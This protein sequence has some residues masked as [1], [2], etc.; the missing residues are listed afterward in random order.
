MS[1]Y[2]ENWIAMAIFAAI[3]AVDLSVLAL[4]LHKGYITFGAGTWSNWRLYAAGCLPAL[5]I[6]TL[7]WENGFAIKALMWG[8]LAL[9]ISPGYYV[10]Q[11]IY[12]GQFHVADIQ[13]LSVGPF[14]SLLCMLVFSGVTFASEMTPAS[15]SV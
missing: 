13:Y 5:V 10:Y 7:Y 11:V 4:C 1:H 15:S 2:K 14:V 8:V 3:M 6:L 9:L 12:E